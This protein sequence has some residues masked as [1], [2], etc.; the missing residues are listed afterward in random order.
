M[1][2]IASFYVNGRPAPQ[3]SKASLGRGR[4]KEQSPHL[5]AW[6]SDVRNA[7]MGHAGEALV[8]G[9]ILV[10][11]VFLFRR[12]N[13]H[14][15]SNNPERE[16]KDGAPVWVAKAPDLDKLQRS[17]NDALTGVIWVDDAQVVATLAQKRFDAEKQGAHIRVWSLAHRH[18]Q[19]LLASTSLYP[20]LE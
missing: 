4:F 14:Y 8:S 10:E 11:Y 19:I 3:G 13:S 15:R 6:R 5:D 7:A 16:F 18:D 2:L 1:E 9:P 17:S 20:V 12:P